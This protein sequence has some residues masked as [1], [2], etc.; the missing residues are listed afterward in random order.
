MDS[1]AIFYKQLQ[2][3]PFLGAPISTTSGPDNTATAHT[4]N[5]SAQEAE[6]DVSSNPA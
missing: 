1:N 6:E 5:P 3:P 4:C 2:K